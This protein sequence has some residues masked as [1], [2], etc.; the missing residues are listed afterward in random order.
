VRCFER[1][2]YG[3][4]A[5]LRDR[6]SRMSDWGLRGTEGAICVQIGLFRRTLVGACQSRLKVADTVDLTT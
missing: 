1:L 6:V 5:S 2:L 3:V 4:G